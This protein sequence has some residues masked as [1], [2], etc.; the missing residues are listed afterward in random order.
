MLG[1]GKK[2]PRRKN[3]VELAAIAA[4]QLAERGLADSDEE[5]SNDEV[6]FITV[7]QIFELW[8]KL[9]L[10][11]LRAARDLFRSQRVAEQELSG[12]VRKL[13]RVT[14]ILRRCVSHFEVIETLTTRDYL[15]FRDKLFP[16]SGFQ[17]RQLRQIEIVLGLQDSE[18]VPFGSAGGYVAALREPDGTASVS[19]KKVQA[20][21]G[22]GES[23]REAIDE[24]LYRTPIDGVT[25][26]DP[27]A[28]IALDRFLT[29]FLESYD[30]E[31]EISR[32]IALSNARDQAE[33]G[34]IDELYADERASVR[35]FLSPNEEKGGARRR[36]IRAAALF[37]ETYRELP[38]LAWPREVLDSLVEM[39]QQLIV[40]RQRHARMVERAIGRR[41]GTGGTAGVAYL[42]KTALK[43]RVFRDLWAIR[44]LQIRREAASD[45]DKPDYYGFLHPE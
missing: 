39:E 29:R 12:V 34:R 8:F 31:S 30:S 24:W 16:A 25:P 13:K 23:L 5:I 14:T 35:A 44:T 19:M 11:E 38:L 4:A 2:A 36:R 9:I 41:A 3:S 18:R 37:V 21:V 1:R 32:G 15:S 45:L 28:V 27:D 20:T 43:Y 26:E 7:H 10:R 33:V 6:L 22:E 42:D 40:F 17:S